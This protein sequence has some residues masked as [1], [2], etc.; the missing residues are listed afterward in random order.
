MPDLAG[1]SERP[2][3]AQRY[4]HMDDEL[5]AG[6]TWLEEP[7]RRR[8]DGPL[9]GRTMLVK[10]LIDTA[11]IRRRG[12]LRLPVIADTHRGGEVAA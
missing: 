4:A 3:G 1:P 7:L 12:Y 5:N 10:D 9:A 11:G 6:I 2:V 8:A